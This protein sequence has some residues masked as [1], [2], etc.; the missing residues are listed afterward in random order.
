MKRLNSNGIKTPGQEWYGVDKLGIVYP[1]VSS[2]V[3][4]TCVVKGGLAGL[5]LMS[6]SFSTDEDIAAYGVVAQG[7][8]EMYVVGMLSRRW[9]TTS[10]EA[11]K[12]RTQ[13]NYGAGDGGTLIAR[14]RKA[15]G[16]AGVV[17][18]S[19]TSSLGAE[20]EITA[21]LAVGA[22]IFKVTAD[23]KEK[24]LVFT[25]VGGDVILPSPKSTPCCIIL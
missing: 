22:V 6:M 9:E 1:E 4:V 20:L 16:F 18:V 10:A 2:C 13:L 5:H 7:A 23:Q 17:S 15:T 12:N 11:S 19:D 3:T 21:Q 24:Q 8:T 14:L 25:Y